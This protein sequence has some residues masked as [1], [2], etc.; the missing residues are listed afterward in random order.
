MGGEGGEGGEGVGDGA[1]GDAH[2]FQRGGGWEHNLK[3]IKCENCTRHV[4][5]T[6]CI[7]SE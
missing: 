4:L 7:L 6:H 1:G 3:L 2:P 5:L